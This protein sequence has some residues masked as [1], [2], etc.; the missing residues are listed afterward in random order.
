M[1]SLVRWEREGTVYIPGRECRRW[2][3]SKN[4]GPP[5]QSVSSS[6]LTSS[7]SQTSSS[8]LSYGISLSEDSSELIFAK[9]TLALCTLT[10]TKSKMA[11]KWKMLHDAFALRNCYRQLNDVVLHTN[12]PDRVSL[13]YFSQKNTRF[14]VFL[15][16]KMA[17][18]SIDH[19]WSKFK[20]KY[21][22]EL[23]LPLLISSLGYYSE[24]LL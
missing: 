1:P 14:V 10:Q 12:C 21:C 24:T 7:S 13:M 16:A 23:K 5:E 4:P 3:G 20:G 11:T 2:V 15:T 19:R 17:C 8:E 22:K 6:P 18:L 9:Y